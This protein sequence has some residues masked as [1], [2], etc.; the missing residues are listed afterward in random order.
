MKI[1]LGLLVRFVQ[2]QQVDI[3]EARVKEEAFNNR[4]FSPWDREQVVMR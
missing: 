1:C 2:L 3:S 4:I